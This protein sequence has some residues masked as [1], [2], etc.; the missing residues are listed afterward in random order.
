MPEYW[1]ICIN[2]GLIGF[3]YAHCQQEAICIALPM[4][5]ILN[6]SLQTIWVCP[7]GP[8][9]FTTKDKIIIGEC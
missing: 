8:R 4:L 1:A 6:I 9:L 2:K 3:A 7:V 5:S